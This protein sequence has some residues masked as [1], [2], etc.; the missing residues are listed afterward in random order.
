MPGLE[1]LYREIILDHYRSPRN[2]GELDV[3]PATKTE[4]FNPLCGD[5]IIVF[6]TLD[7]DTVTDIKIAGQGCSIS[8]SSASM[9]SAAVKG[10]TRAE[11]DD[12]TRAFKSMM[13][14]HETSLGGT[15]EGNGDG[16][17]DGEIIEA[18]DVKLGDLEALQGVVKF[19]VRIKCATLSWNTL[20][21]AI[22][23]AADRS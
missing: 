5:E 11:V 19:P 3:P 23:E 10:R 15:P 16:D 13:S 9:M 6:V 12:L 14:I 20:A 4:G 21:Q 1:D 7:G 17:P 8:Q 22:D 18:P 2:R